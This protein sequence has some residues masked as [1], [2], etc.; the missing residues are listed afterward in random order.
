M[1][2]LLLAVSAAAL[3]ACSSYDLFA[4][5]YGQQNAGVANACSGL[6]YSACGYNNAAPGVYGGGLAPAPS[7]SDLQPYSG[8]NAAPEYVY[9]VAQAGYHNMNHG[10]HQSAPNVNIPAI[11]GSGY[12]GVS[13]PRYYTNI[14][15]V[16]YDVADE[17]FGI[18][19]RIGVQNGA[20]GAEAEGSFGV[21][22]DTQRFDGFVGGN[23]AELKASAGAR[24]S[25]AAFATARMP[26]V[27]RLDAFGRVGYH[28][29]E[30]EGKVTADGER[31][32]RT[33]SHSDGLAYGGGLE[34]NLDPM[35]AIRVDY[36]RYESD[37]FITSDSVSASFVS[38][39]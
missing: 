22:D 17:A 26:I 12:E 37:D 5:E 23:P 13:A 11:R 19:G 25:T 36:T 18:V 21:I 15:G 14:G 9:P 24:W 29:T 32:A 16:M 8:Y 2:I 31:L 20:F 7:A 1:R 3:S 38:R 39:F 4:P 34:Y 33:R 6:V 35:R 28:I 30:F 27:P 10:A